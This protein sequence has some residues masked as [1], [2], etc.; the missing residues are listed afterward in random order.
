MRPYR[1]RI[2]VQTGTG[3]YIATSSTT[4]PGERR[5]I[6]RITAQNLSS[7]A[8]L[9]TLGIG[10]LGYTHYL[11]AERITNAIPT[12]IADF[13]LELREGEYLVFEIRGCN[14]NDD[15]EIWLTGWEWKS[16]V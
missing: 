11:N 16:V 1:E 10:G 7:D 3:T 9:V 8:G 13:P 12:T 6:Y 2:R 5:K 15:V 4:K 14:A